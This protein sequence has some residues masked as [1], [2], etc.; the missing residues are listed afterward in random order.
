MLITYIILHIKKKEFNTIEIIIFSAL[1]G[2]ITLPSLYSSA[3]FKYEKLQ[4]IKQGKELINKN[5]AKYF[6][7]KDYKIKFKGYNDGC[8]IICTDTPTYSYEINN[9]KIDLNYNITLNAKTLEI[10]SDM[11][12]E[13]FLEKQNINKPLTNYLRLLNVLP[14]SVSVNG[15]VKEIDFKNLNNDYSDLNIL[16]NSTFI[17]EN[18]Y[19]DFGI[20][21]KEEI[22]KELLM[23]SISLLDY[24]KVKIELVLLLM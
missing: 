20:F 12:I 15:R 5:L 10:E 7:K 18:F 16:S 1:I 11:L 19:V 3:I 9:T 14:L 21:N 22:I 6:E 8:H 4:G 23:I 24:L 17:F 13:D 2:I